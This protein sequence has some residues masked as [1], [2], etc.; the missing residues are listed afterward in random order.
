M[1]LTD[2]EY[3]VVAW[4][5]EATQLYGWAAE[6]VFGK[7][8]V[9]MAMWDHRPEDLLLAYRELEMT[10]H[11][12]GTMR[13]LRRDGA[14]IAVA[15]DAHMI[16]GHDGNPLGM[17]SVNALAAQSDAEAEADVLLLDELARGIARDELAL[18]YQPIVDAEGDC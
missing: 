6:E 17:V 5:D 15:C 10:G 4:N 3:K 11:W 7:S 13:H 14:T 9:D 1:I 16:H 18:A 2:L 12:K 8:L